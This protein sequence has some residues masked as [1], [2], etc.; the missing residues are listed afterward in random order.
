ME[1]IFSQLPASVS[2]ADPQG[3][4][5]PPKPVRTTIRRLTADIAG[6]SVRSVLAGKRL[7]D[8][9][10]SAREQHQLF[11][12]NQEEHPFTEEQLMQ[13]WAEYL[14]SLNDRPNLKASLNRQPIWTPDGK[15][16]LKI[17]NL[18]Q[19]ELIRDEKPRLVAWL[20]RELRNGSLELNTQ[21]V[22]EPARKMIYTDGEKLEEM[23][24][25]NPTL[26]LLKQKFNLD[27]DT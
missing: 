11:S 9:K 10:M 26:A 2:A 4:A 19:E 12:R 3:G 14:E 7:Q 18:V 20:K 25:K 15:L 6:P 22:S 8:E 17:D 1:P 21:M 24:R 16:V 5:E 23:V 13:K 27:F